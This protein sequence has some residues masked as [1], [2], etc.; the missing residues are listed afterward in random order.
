MTG[1]LS[2]GLLSWAYPPE[3]SGLSRA[4]REIAESL[5]ARGHGVRVFTMDRDV[6]EDG[7]VSVIGCALQE[8]SALARVRSLGAAGHL[9]A[10]FAL[11]RAVLAEHKR[12]PFDILEATNWYA[13]GLFIA[14]D[15]RLRLVTR[16]STPAAT[17]IETAS[18]L[19][20]RIDKAS[21]CMIE[22]IS[23]RLS[24]RLI[25][26]TPDHGEKMAALYGVPPPGPGHDVIG[27]S[28]PASLLERAEAASYPHETAPVRLL[29]IGR[30]EARKGADVLF[31]ALERLA[32]SAALPAFSIDIVGIA[33]DEIAPLSANLRPRVTFHH[34]LDDHALHDAMADAHIIAAPSRYESF[35][36]VY[37]EALAFGRPVVACAEDPSARRFIGATGA[38]SLAACSEP[39]ALAKALSAMIAEP[40]RRRACRKAA[41]SAAGRFTRETLGLETERAYRSVLTAPRTDA[42]APARPPAVRRLRA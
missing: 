42:G 11:W 19:R 5:A 28:L 40:E 41:L 31:P 3:K 35:G 17:S 8:G 21:A 32:A 4:A 12:Q 16:N 20:A 15:P 1:S 13:P 34:R 6:R 29:F 38:G 30:N 25:S 24:S 27:L 39:G 22:K 33:E 23:A 37:Q 10:P 26:N 36:L 14:A 7:A 2:I 18:T 9:A